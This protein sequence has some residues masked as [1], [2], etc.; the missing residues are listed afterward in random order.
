MRNLSLLPDSINRQSAFE[1]LRTSIYIGLSCS[2]VFSDWN[3]SI[4]PVLRLFGFKKALR[5]PLA[6]KIVFRI[7]HLGRRVLK[8]LGFLI[9][10]RGIVGFIIAQP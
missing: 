2:R 3:W 8:L 5:N 1:E 4:I 6:G 7:D 10:G 9:R